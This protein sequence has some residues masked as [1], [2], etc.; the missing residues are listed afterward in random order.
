M[1]GESAHLYVQRSLASDADTRV[2]AWV[3][4][5]EAEAPTTV[6]K[7]NTYPASIVAWW[8]MEEGAGTTIY[9]RTSNANNGTMTNMDA[10]TDWVQDAN[11]NYALDFDGSNDYIAVPHSAEFNNS[12]M[13]IL[14]RISFNARDRSYAT[15]FGKKLVWNGATGYYVEW[16]DVLDNWKLR[17]SGAEYPGVAHN[18]ALDTYYSLGFVFDGT[19]GTAYVDSTTSGGGTIDQIVGDATD[20]WIGSF[21]GGA[22]YWRG[23]IE[24]MFVAA[25]AFSADEIA[26]H[27]LMLSDPATWATAGDLAAVSTN[28]AHFGGRNLVKPMFRRANL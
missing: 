27:H 18:P 8:P 13:S 5:A 9:D 26:A 16:N 20:I 22:S 25:D 21:V 6:W 24:S 3:G 28:R 12:Q 11:G 14:T 23:R 1:A 10:A 15:V 19:T 7:Q 4:N 17:G 2:W